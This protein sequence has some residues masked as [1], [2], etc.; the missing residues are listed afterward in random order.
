[1]TE[2]LT[3]DDVDE[4]L[5]TRR[6]RLRPLR[7]G[8]APAIA[9]YLA[10]YDV[11]KMLGHVPFPYKLKDA[12]TFVEHHEGERVFAIT[13]KASGELIGITSLR[14]IS[15]KHADLGYWLGRPH[16][17]HG[18]ATE[19]AQRM[20]DYGFETLKLARI[21]ADCRVVN[22]ASRRVLRKCGF[23]FCGPGML[24]TLAS[25]RVASEHYAMDRRCWEAIRAWGRS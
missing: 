23:P 25:G 17:G 9:A 10:D 22:E 18:Y 5:D 4:S 3:A 6:L 24:Q 14:S 13:L 16:W 11:A 20:I 8:D 19:A 21:D 1:M 2:D 15:P 12:E 7:R